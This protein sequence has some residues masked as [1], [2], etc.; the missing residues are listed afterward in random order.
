MDSVTIQ[1]LIEAALPDA[2]VSVQGG[3]GKFEAVVISP[4]FAGKTLIQRQRMVNAAVREPLASGALHALS[5]R[6]LLPEEV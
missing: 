3:E 4:S 2:K 1:K 6:T 5:M